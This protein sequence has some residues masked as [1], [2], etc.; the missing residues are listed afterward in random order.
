VS[1]WKNKV[2][3]VTGGSAGLGLAIGRA[4]ARCGAKVVLLARNKEPLEAAAETLRRAG[5]DVT[6]IAGDVA[7]QEDVDRLAAS[8]NEQFGRLDFLCNCAGRSTRGTALETSPE[9][10]QQLLEVNFLSTVRTTRA[11]S[12]LLLSS[13]GHL[14]NIGSLASKVGARYMGAY[15]AS[16]FAVAAYTQQLR[17]ELGERGLHVMLVC[18]GPIAREGAG[19]RYA[20]A[21][22]VPADAQAPGAGARL[23]TIDSVWLAGAILK[24]CERRRPELV[25]PAKA[26]LLFAISQLSA[27]W[28]DWLLRKMTK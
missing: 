11:L 3:L 17:L 7:W 2:C 15:P 1:Y 5:G 9:D 6:T 27:S 25:V 10:F 18:P 12:P 19:P 26:K 8:V 13:R 23:N 16:K 22:G 20:A 24:A 14:V 4:L 21:E 28:G